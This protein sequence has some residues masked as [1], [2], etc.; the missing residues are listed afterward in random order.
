MKDQLKFILLFKL[1]NNKF[2]TIIHQLI[3]NK[4]NINNRVK[5][6]VSKKKRKK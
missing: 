4:I 2:K 1:K 6:K 3:S 5:I